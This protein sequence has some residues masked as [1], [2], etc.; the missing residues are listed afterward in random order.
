MQDLSM[1]TFE[2]SI[3]CRLYYGLVSNATHSLMSGTQGITGDEPSRNTESGR[4]D[5]SQG[6]RQGSSRRNGKRGGGNSGTSREGSGESRGAFTSP[7]DR[8]LSAIVI[9]GVTTAFLDVYL[10]KDPIASEWLGRDAVR[11]VGE[12]GELRRK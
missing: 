2:S 12:R 5:Q 10:K 7:T 4:S 6:S 11:W 1:T 9:E 3:S 8:S